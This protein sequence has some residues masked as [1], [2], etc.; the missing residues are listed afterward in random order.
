MRGNSQSSQPLSNQLGKLRHNQGKDLAKVM[1]G[2]NQ[3]RAWL[4][5]VGH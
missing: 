2:D 3:K 1:Q 4:L 5:T